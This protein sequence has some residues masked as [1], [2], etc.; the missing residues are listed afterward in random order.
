[1]RWQDIDARSHFGTIP[2]EF[3]KNAHG[4]RAYLNETPRKLLKDVPRDDRAVWVFPKSVM[5]DYKHVGRRLAQRTRANIV[6]APKADGAARD[7]ADIRG[8]DLRRT[9]RVSWPVAASR[10]L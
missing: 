10:V 3:V 7:R 5:G 1:M 9:G 6:A 8:H 2:A 4:H